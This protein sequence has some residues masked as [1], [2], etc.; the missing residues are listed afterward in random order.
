MKKLFDTRFWIV[1]V[2]HPL[3]ILIRGEIGM[4]PNEE[5]Q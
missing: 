5:K 4:N 2:E 3:Q 1:A